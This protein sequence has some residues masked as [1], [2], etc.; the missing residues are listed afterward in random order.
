M[1][2]YKKPIISSHVSVKGV[3]PLAGLTLVE[4]LAGAA[5]VA[6]FLTG[7]GDDDFHPEHTRTLTERKNFA[8]G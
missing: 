4:V 3:V 5:A 6:G 7:M 1:K 2:P 8:L